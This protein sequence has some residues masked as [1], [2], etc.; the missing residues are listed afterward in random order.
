MF[1]SREFEEFGGSSIMGGTKALDFQT[2][3]FPISPETKPLIKI[4][5]SWRVMGPL[6]NA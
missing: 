1:Q 5:R 4:P 6:D 3:S 2:A